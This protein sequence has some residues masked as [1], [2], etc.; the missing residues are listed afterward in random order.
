[1]YYISSSVWHSR[2]K[3]DL[4]TIVSSIVRASPQLEKM[5]L[6]TY[7]PSDD[8]GQPAHLW[9]DYSLLF[10]LWITKDQMFPQGLGGWGQRRLW[11][12]CG[13]AR[14]NPIPRQARMFKSTYSHVRT[15]SLYKHFVECVCVGRGAGVITWGN[16]GTGVWAS[17]LKPTPFIYLAFEKTVPFQILYRPKCWPIHILSFDFNTN[18]L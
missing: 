11:S 10:F 13:D 6:L 9:S 15:R 2:H 17:I 18:L 16:C 12:I 8:S 14:A 4:Q 5:Y 3:Q 7:A 1:M